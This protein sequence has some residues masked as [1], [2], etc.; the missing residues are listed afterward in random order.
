MDMSDSFL[1][2]DEIDALLRNESPAAAPAATTAPA[3][4]PVAAPA[5]PATK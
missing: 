1:S 5:A 4:A 3:K 2:Q